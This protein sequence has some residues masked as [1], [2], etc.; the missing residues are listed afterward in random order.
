MQAAARIRRLSN[1]SH[2]VNSAN[3]NNGR[4]NCPLI[5]APRPNTRSFK[6]ELNLPAEPR[7]AVDIRA[8]SLDLAG[9]ALIEADPY[10]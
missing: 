9:L 5:A 2:T 6:D 1:T 8:I 7:D 10:A 3:S 4:A